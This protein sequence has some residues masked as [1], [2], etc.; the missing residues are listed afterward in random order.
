M[1][2]TA[3]AVGTAI[4]LLSAG[5][6]APVTQTLGLS[7]YESVVLTDSRAD[8][9]FASASSVLQTADTATD[10]TCELTLQRSGTTQI[11]DVPRD[12][13]SSTSYA[14]ACAAPGRVHAVTDITYCNGACPDCLGCADFP[15]RCI[16]VVR[17]TEPL[18]GILWAHEYGHNVGNGHVS[19]PNMVMRD[20]VEG[21][22]LSVTA[23][24][25]E[26]YLDT[27]LRYTTRATTQQPASPAR[28]LDEFVRLTFI[29]GVPYEEAVRFG[30]Q[31]V[32]RLLELLRTPPDG[33]RLSNVVLTLGMIG[34]PR[35]IGPLREFVSQG[36][37]QTLARD[38]FVAK[39]SALVALGYLYF[40][41]RDGSILTFLTDGS[42]P[43][44]WGLRV[45]WRAQDDSVQVPRALA[46]TSVQALGLT[47]SPDA[48]TFLGSAFAGVDAEFAA[49]ASDASRQNALV[50]QQ[51]QAAFTTMRV[52]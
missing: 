29:H 46:L 31:A 13:T 9:I 19:T 2:A 22:N 41:T 18:E 40:R 12:I 6:S 14:A 45:Q 8:A 26:R 35:A 36:A 42:R 43:D 24:Q 52:Q 50:L 28:S 23:A 49:V 17:H 47:G 38:L 7:R 51:G 11:F 20:T 21:G 4:W 30:R 16:T 1:I 32:D 33:V 34:D 39:R 27:S 5:A 10:V 44:F 37:G 25:C 3:G 48:A 15:G